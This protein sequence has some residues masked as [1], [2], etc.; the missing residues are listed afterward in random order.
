MRFYES[1]RFGSRIPYWECGRFFCATKRFD[2]AYIAFRLPGYANESAKI[3]KCG[4]E[5]RGIRS[6]EKTRFTLPK[7]FPARV[8]IDRFPQIEKPRQNASGVGLNDWNA[9][10]ERETG[11]R[12]RGV[13]ADAGELLHL[14]GCPR[15]LSTVSIHNDSR[16]GVKI[17][18]ASVIAKTLPRAQ[19]LV[20]GSPCKRGEIGKRTEPLVII[21]DDGRD[22]RLLEHE[23]GDKYFVRIVGPAPGEMA[24]VTAIPT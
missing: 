10:I 3:E 9:S 5:S 24:A 2:G 6:W 21:R 1:F 20:F 8:R 4:V 16:C 19:H 18:R 14:V 7:R 15:E 23:L 12:M 11:H 22:L 13:S 17:S